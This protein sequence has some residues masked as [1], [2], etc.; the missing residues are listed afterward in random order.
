MPN[1]KMQKWNNIVVNFIDGT[2]D[3]FVNGTL[4]NSFSVMEE[5]K[6]KS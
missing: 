5:F 1:L 6:Y 2:Y 4:V 3:L